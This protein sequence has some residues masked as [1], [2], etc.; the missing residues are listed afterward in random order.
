MFLIFLFFLALLSPEDVTLFLNGNLRLR[1]FYLAGLAL[2][3]SDVLIRVDN[4]LLFPFLPLPALPIALLR[5]SLLLPDLFLWRFLDLRI[6]N[7]VL[8]SKINEV[9]LKT[10]V[11][12]LEDILLQL[13]R[14]EL[15][16]LL[17]LDIGLILDVGF[18][19]HSDLVLFVLVH[20]LLGICV[21]EK[22]LRRRPLAALIFS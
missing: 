9:I 5:S 15:I 18:V 10:L 3:L 13:M 1:L 17:L 22:V 2:L 21:E 4:G 6:L 11:I 14:I 7:D 19:H 12:I 16:L 20:K 8:I